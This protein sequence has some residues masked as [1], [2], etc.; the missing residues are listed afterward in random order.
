MHDEG[1]RKRASFPKRAEEQR[2]TG[3]VRVTFKYLKVKRTTR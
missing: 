3:E 1:T 2:T